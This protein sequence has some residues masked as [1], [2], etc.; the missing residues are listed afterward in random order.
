M[1]DFAW[2]ALRKRVAVSTSFGVFSGNIGGVIMQ[3]VA[4]MVLAA[5]LGYLPLFLFAAASYLLALGW[6][7][8]MLPRIEPI[9]ADRASPDPVAAH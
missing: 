4:G 6:I 9:E 5:S 3:K 7:R 8:L 2:R 1:R